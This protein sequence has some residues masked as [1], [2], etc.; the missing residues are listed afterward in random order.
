MASLFDNQPA[1]S[2]SI[3]QTFLNDAQNRHLK[4][5]C[6]GAGVMGILHAYNIQKYCQNINFAI[7]DKNADIGGTWWENRYPGCA[8]DIPSHSYAYHFAPNPDWP[9]FLSPREDIW[10]YLDRDTAQ[11]RINLSRTTPNG[12]IEEFQESCDVFF[13][14]TGLLNNWKMPDIEGLETFKGRV[15]HTANWPQDYTQEKWKDERVLVIGS[16]A[17]SLQVVSNIQPYVKSMDVFVRT[18]V[19]FAP[20][21]DGI[22]ETYVYTE[23]QKAQ[24]RNE[25]EKL[26]EH[27]KFTENQLNRG[28]PGFF[29]GSEMQKVMKAGMS[30]RMGEIIKDP[31]LLQGFTP[32]FAVGCRRITPGEPYMNAIQQPNTKVHFMAVKKVMPTGVIGTDGTLLEG[33]TLICA[34][35]FDVSFLPHFPIIGR[36]GVDLREKWKTVASAYFGL[37]VPDMPNLLLSGGPPLPVQNGTPFGVFHTTANYM[38]A[39][40]QK[41]QTDNIRSIEPKKD[42]TV[43]FLKYVEEYHRDTVFSDSCRS[44]YKDNDT[45]RVTAV[46][47]GSALHYMELLKTPRWEDFKIDYRNSGNMFTFL[48]NGLVKEIVTPGADVSSYLQ[49]DKIDA[50]WLQE[51]KSVTH[52]ARSTAIS[53]QCYIC[54]L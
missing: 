1:G 48:G 40:L 4:V 38:M 22:P 6:A 2:V 26:I 53:A 33:D 29:K 41:M 13:C 5:I 24:F 51:L 11:W 17:S 44:W 9:H 49:V 32:D 16:G 7:Y 25:P 19:W 10:A 37:T 54:S 45:G 23:E 34:T 36:G 14:C 39:T 27:I 21:T 52:G 50:L 12:D 28:W 31:Y 20:L 3:S 47:P 42:V 46:W 35:G 8:C 43:A 15:L 30:Q 18:G